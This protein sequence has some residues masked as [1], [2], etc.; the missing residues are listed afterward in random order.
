LSTDLSMAL[1]IFTDLNIGAQ[2]QP[3]QPQLQPLC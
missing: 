1:G 2:L 3:L